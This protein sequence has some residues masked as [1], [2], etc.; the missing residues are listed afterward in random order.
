MKTVR[1]NVQGMTCDHCKSAVEKA[2]TNQDGVRAA[3]VHLQENAAEVQYDETRVSPE[4]MIAA[5]GEEGYDA[6]VA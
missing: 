1:L 2:L 6:G 4:Q 3:T 5:V